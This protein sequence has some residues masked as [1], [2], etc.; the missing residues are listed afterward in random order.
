VRIPWIEEIRLRSALAA[1]ES[2]GHAEA[3]GDICVLVGALDRIMNA[4]AEIRG[5]PSREPVWAAPSKASVTVR[6]EGKDVIELEDYAVRQARQFFGD[7]DGAM[8]VAVVPGYEI[9]GYQ[10]EIHGDEVRYVT[11]TA[12]VT[13]RE[14]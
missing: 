4:V 11:F 1:P 5:E 6:V 13:V 14:R 8:L 3:I 12:S 9:S 10:Y 7:E 2:A